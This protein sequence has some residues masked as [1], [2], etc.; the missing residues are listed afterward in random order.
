MGAARSSRFT[1]TVVPPPT[2]GLLS[3]FHCNSRTL[4]D[5]HPQT[6][7]PLQVTAF[8][9]SDVAKTS[10]LETRR[11]EPGERWDAESLDAEGG[12][13]F[14]TEGTI[15]AATA[16]AAHA[17]VGTVANL[18]SRAKRATPVTARA[19]G[20]ST[21]PPPPAKTAPPRPAEELPARRA[22]F[23][24][25]AAVQPRA[26]ASAGADFAAQT[27][28]AGG[29]LLAQGILATARPR[30]VLHRAAPVPAAFHIWPSVR[31]DKLDRQR[32]QAGGRRGRPCAGAAARAAS[33]RA[34]ERRR[35]RG[36]GIFPGACPSGR[37]EPAPPCARACRWM[38]WWRP[39]PGPWFRPSRLVSHCAPGPGYGG[40]RGGRQRRGCGGNSPRALW[41]GA[42]QQA[43]ARR[44]GG[45]L[46]AHHSAGVCLL[47]IAIEAAAAAAAPRW[48]RD[49]RRGWCA[50]RRCN[51]TGWRGAASSGK[52]GKRGEEG[53]ALLPSVPGPTTRSP[54]A[55]NRALL[56]P[57]CR[58][59]SSCGCDLRQ[60]WTAVRRRRTLG[61]WGQW[62][63]H[64]CAVQEM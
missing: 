60:V 55:P 53:E 10:P 13:I 33:D 5:H 24:V 49:G 18:V 30:P 21:P 50:R 12:L 25:E 44:S 29:V 42:R 45:G 62:A 31:A 20:A 22:A 34:A 48:G 11:L 27:V 3:W 1:N 40:A 56:R 63:Q 16:S 19:S 14:Q 8:D 35:P 36:A 23:Q 41:R 47:W 57:S 64:R 43:R 52:R 61:A 46:C 6:P 9:A 15:T 17:G 54:S 32:H 37:A 26:E 7:Q 28:E 38:A 4:T 59:L 51:V 39:F 58:R 2:S